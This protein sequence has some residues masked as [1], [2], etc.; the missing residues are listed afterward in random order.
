VAQTLFKLHHS[1]TS[2]CGLFILMKG[3][4]KVD[5]ITLIVLYAIFSSL[6]FLVNFYL[7]YR[8]QSV[9]I[10]IKYYLSQTANAIYMI[11]CIINWS[12]QLYLFYGI[13]WN[14]PL[15]H[16]I[17]YLFFLYSVVKDDLIL[18]R[19]LHNDQ[20]QYNKMIVK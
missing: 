14:V 7:G 10:M 19:W 11:S 16:T 3:D 12:L 17:L 1:T 4:N 15:H 2:L 6:T 8:V 13:I 9:N 5:I 18:M 20:I